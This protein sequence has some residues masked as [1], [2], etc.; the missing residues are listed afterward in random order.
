MTSGPGSDDAI[1]QV[2]TTTPRVADC[3]APIAIGGWDDL[4]NC[5]EA[6]EVALAGNACIDDPVIVNR[7]WRNAFGVRDVVGD[8]VWTNVKTDGSRAGNNTC[9]NWTSNSNQEQGQG[10]KARVLSPSWTDSASTSC[11]N[12]QARL[13][14]FEDFLVE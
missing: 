7:G 13:Y 10:G 12:N 11:V 2:R 5:Q 14:C 8:D 6:H 3:S 4:I 9:V 1:C